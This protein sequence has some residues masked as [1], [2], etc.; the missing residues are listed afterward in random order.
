MN[1]LEKLRRILMHI[2]NGFVKFIV[3]NAAVL[4]IIMLLPVLVV[5]DNVSVINH[6]MDYLFAGK[7]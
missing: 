1:T 6:M 3:A 5:T 7:S 2:T 4:L